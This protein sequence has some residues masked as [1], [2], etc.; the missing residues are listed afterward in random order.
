MVELQLWKEGA[1]LGKSA[2]PLVGPEHYSKTSE[3]WGFN[4]DPEY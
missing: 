3:F 2:P 1:L 4:L